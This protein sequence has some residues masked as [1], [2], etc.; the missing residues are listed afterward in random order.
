MS[1]LWSL[2]IHRSDAHLNRSPVFLS[3][4]QGMQGPELILLCSDCRA[5]C[6]DMESLISWQPC[7]VRIHCKTLAQEDLC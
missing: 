1:E 5:G 4:S 2:E 7:S 6:C 3:L